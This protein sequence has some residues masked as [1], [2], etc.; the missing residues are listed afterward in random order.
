MDSPSPPPSKR[1]RTD[2]LP[3]PCNHPR[4]WF[5]D[6]N[7][8]L[9]AER[10][11]FKVFRGILGL[12]STVFANLFQDAHPDGVVGDD[13]GVDG[14]PLIRLADTA[15]DVEIMLNALYASGK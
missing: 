1:P 11:Q 4:L 5:A 8:V 9:E 2:E 12:H 6:G 7:V 13:S 3:D 10:V 15:A 14:C